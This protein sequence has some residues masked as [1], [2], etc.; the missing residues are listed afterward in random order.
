MKGDA[1]LNS[2]L[3]ID[4]LTNGVKDMRPRSKELSN[5]FL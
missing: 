1:L 4:K 5:K 2:I 3:S